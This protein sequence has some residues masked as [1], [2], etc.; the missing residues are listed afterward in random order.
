MFLHYLSHVRRKS[1]VVGLKDMMRRFNDANKNVPASPIIKHF[2]TD[3]VIFL[4]YLGES[5][6][7]RR[8][9]LFSKLCFEYTKTSVTTLPNRILFVLG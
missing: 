8:I 4:K 1:T 3:I 9:L 2:F 7:S 5:V 6:M